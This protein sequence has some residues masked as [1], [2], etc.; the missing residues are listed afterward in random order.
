MPFP[1]AVPAV[2]L[3]IKATCLLLAALAASRLLRRASAGSRH[4]VWLVALVGLLA[5]P[6]VAAWAPLPVR[7]L[8]PAAT[9]AR[10]G[11]Q[12]DPSPVQFHAAG[13][14]ATSADPAAVVRSAPAGTGAAATLPAA[15]TG[16][17]EPA[18]LAAMLV[19]AWA[20]VA[21]ALALRLGYGAWSVRRIV[22]RACPLDGDAW[23]VPLWEIA[24]RLG[25]DSAPRLVRSEDVKMPFAAGLVTS[26]IV[27]PSESDGWSAERRSAVLVHEL[28]HVRRR[29]LIGHTLGRVACLL[30]W[31]HPL[32]WTAARRL[33][34]ESERACDDLALVFGARP[35]DYAEHLLDIVA[36]VRDHATPAVALA[37]AHRGEFEGRMLAILDPDLRRRS[38]GRL[39]TFCLVG[40]VAALALAVGAAAPVPRQAEPAR[41]PGSN[42]A[43]VGAAATS[44]GV[45]ADAQVADSIGGGSLDERGQ[46]DADA[47]VPGL[48]RGAPKAE[49]GA[50]IQ[51]EAAS[52]T[53]RLEA[54]VAVAA[55]SGDGER[56]AVL[57]KMLRTDPSASVRRV[58]AWGLERY[59]D[60][61]VAL[62]ALTSA[63]TGDADAE[64]REMAAW[65]LAGARGSSVAGAA[66]IKALRQ[67]RDHQVRATAVW[68]LGS[69]RDPAAVEPL[70]AALRDENAETREMAAWAIGSCRPS[71]APA[72]LVT[73]LG[74]RERDVRLSV[75]WAL[76]SIKDPG[77]TRAIEA[78]YGREADGE[79]RIGLIK[80]LG[81][82]G[83]GSVEVL[84]RLL[85]SPDSLVRQTAVTELAGGGA[86]G[87]WPWPR[88]EPRPFP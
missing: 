81:A 80:A 29:D 76:Y 30:Y 74:D 32:V 69:V 64:V 68:A 11:S 43:Q 17:I 19:G 34:A 27:L 77:T 8:P 42:Q 48:T 28:G 35:S 10:P 72:A 23:Q 62:T 21:L 84:Q 15:R 12:A 2:L 67:D 71:A 61:E 56:A 79:V 50:A 86:S 83:D 41:E 36:G 57:A 14:T 87:P 38:P 63:V 26:T 51:D 18:G 59:A 9:L 66:L 88:P 44:R 16:L 70:V 7:V 1:V 75:A 6:A 52:A 78:A 13:E 5:L 40:G 4:L 3:L 22:R 25:L 46:H 85:T 65:A 49:T 31:F 73:G 58:A 33:R 20:V 55:D 39:Q 47:A 24:D 45:Q 53:A 60:T 82:L 37:L 54:A